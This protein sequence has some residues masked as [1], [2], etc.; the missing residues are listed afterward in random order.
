MAD[1][2][3]DILQASHARS[4]ARLKSNGTAVLVAV[5]DDATLCRILNQ[6]RPVLNQQARAQMVAALAAVDYVLI[7]PEAS[8]DSLVERLQPDQVE[9]AS[10]GRNIIGEIL[11]RHK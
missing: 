10:D 8:L 2:C 5:Y 11:D 7:W 1:G 3:F 4:L 9:H 6:S